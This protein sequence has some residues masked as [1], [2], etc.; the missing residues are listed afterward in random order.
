MHLSSAQRQALA[1]MELQAHRSAWAIELR[2]G[3][4]HNEIQRSLLELE[5]RMLVR[6]LPLVDLSRLGLQE[7][8]VIVEMRRE[9]RLGES[10]LGSHHL[11]WLASLVP[12]DRYAFSIIATCLNEAA[13][14]YDSPSRAGIPTWCTSRSTLASGIWNSA[15]KPKIGGGY[16][17]S[18]RI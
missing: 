12:G 7:F 16:T 10:L 9:N 8:V 11:S 17:N 6:K 18:P 1:A 2:A 3:I 4:D 15:S 13:E 5:Q 14:R